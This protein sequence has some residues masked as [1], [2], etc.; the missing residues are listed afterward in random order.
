MQCSFREV[1]TYRCCSEELW[2]SVINCAKALTVAVL[3]SILMRCPKLCKRAGANYIP[4]S[5]VF[6]VRSSVNILA[7][8]L[9]SHMEIFWFAIGSVG[10]KPIGH[11][12][13]NST[14]IVVAVA[15]SFVFCFIYIMFVPYTQISW[16][17]LR[18]AEHV[19]L[20]HCPDALDAPS[21][22]VIGNLRRS[23]ASLS[24]AINSQHWWIASHCTVE[25]ASWLS[26]V[27]VQW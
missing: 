12:L 11:N 26:T 3:L 19:L 10:R 15:V 14:T 1:Q 24:H 5:V 2:W 7:L 20:R 21:D 8:R 13:R 17:C 6:L 16:E 22:F 27:S 4:C 23:Y 9:S 18:C 25:A